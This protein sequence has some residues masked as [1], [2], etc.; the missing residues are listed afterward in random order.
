MIGYMGC[1]K[2]STGRRVARS[3]GVRFVD[4]DAEVE[5]EEQATVLDI[6]HYEGESYFRRAER[7]VLDRILADEGDMIVATGGG[8][9]LRDDNMDIM[10]DTGITVYIKRSAESIF[11]RMSDY[12]RKKRPKL[13]DMSDEEVLWYM[14]RD[15]EK[16][17]HTYRLSEYKFDADT[18]NDANLAASIVRIWREHAQR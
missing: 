1:G 14:E 6:F 8:L 3:L 15:I 7:R 12:G 4:T 10:R 2:S 9:P 17:D 18:M 5:R 13:R 16:R 11:G